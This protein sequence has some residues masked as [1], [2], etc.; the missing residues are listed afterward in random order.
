MPGPSLVG[1]LGAGAVDT[2]LNWSSGTPIY[3]E[4]GTAAGKLGSRGAVIAERRGSQKLVRYTDEDSNEAYD[5][6]VDPG[7]LNALPS[8][9]D[10]Y[11]WA[12]GLDE[13]AEAKQ[14]ID[15]KRQ[16]RRNKAAE[17]DGEGSDDIPEELKQKLRDLGYVDP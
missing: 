15:G 13:W 11:S 7:E 4:A 17:N 10:V 6:G 1:L 5:L 12:A 8:R 14:L 3:S 2:A 9:H 16:G